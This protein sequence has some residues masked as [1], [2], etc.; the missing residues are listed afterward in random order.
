M[1]AVHRSEQQNNEPIYCLRW[2]SAAAATE[3]TLWRPEE[4]EV[5]ANDSYVTCPRLY[6]YT[7]VRGPSRA[8][9]LS[10]SDC[11]GVH[12]SRYRVIDE[13]TPARQRRNKCLHE[14]PPQQLAIDTKSAP[15][16]WTKIGIHANE[17]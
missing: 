12:F 5:Q 14:R 11:Y 6:A 10:L 13:S 7:L 15:R 8:L 1:N 9:Y 4:H 16:K 3:N 17:T 2:G